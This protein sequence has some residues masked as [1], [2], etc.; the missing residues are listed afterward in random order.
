MKLFNPEEIR[1]TEI[2]LYFKYNYLD[3]YELK[4]IFDQIDRLYK[5]FLQLSY[6]VYFSEKY[7]QAYRNF[8][9]IESINTGQSIKIK[10]KEG[11]K[12]EFR[13]KKKNL[14]IGIPMKLGIPALAVYFLFVGAQRIMDI[15]NDYLDAE[16]KELEIQLQQIEIYEKIEERNQ[17]N[18]NKTQR[19]FQQQANGVINYIIQNKNINYVEINGITIKESE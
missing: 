10:F 9:E 15:R 17:L 14:V 7:D 11:W 12:P 18:G 1:D 2:E 13:V 3:T 19:L 5:N 8:L 4:E 16:L 6:P